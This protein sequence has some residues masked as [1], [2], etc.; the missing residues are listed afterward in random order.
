MKRYLTPIQEAEN[1]DTIQR[2]PVD[3][4]PVGVYRL[5]D[6]THEVVAEINGRTRRLG[7]RDAGVSRKNDDGVA[8]V[9]LKPTSAGLTVINRDSTNPIVVETSPTDH[10]LAKHEDI[11]ITDDCTIQLGIGVRIRANVRGTTDE[12]DDAM[13]VEDTPNGPEMEAY[14]DTLTENIILQVNND[15]VADCRNKLQELHDTIVEKPVDAEPY[16][17]IEEQLEQTMTKLESKIND[18]I[19]TKTI[20]EELQDEINHLTSR[21]VNMYDRN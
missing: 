7:V 5:D 13:D 10:K 15:D 11:E 1:T 8:P 14:L 4:G 17:E 21:V 9:V 2:I 16:D 6:G 18:K 3:H 20:G 12:T 19:R